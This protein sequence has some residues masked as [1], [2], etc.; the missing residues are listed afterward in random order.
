MILATVITLVP[1]PTAR[2]RQMQGVVARARPDRAATLDDAGRALRG[3]VG[4]SV[5]PDVV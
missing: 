5:V 3:I 1:V 2:M 4:R